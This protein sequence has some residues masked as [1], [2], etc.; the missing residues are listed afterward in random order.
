MFY[1]TFQDLIN[2]VQDD[3]SPRK[4]SHDVREILGEIDQKKTKTVDDVI[5]VIPHVK[6]LMAKPQR[7]L[8]DHSDYYVAVDLNTNTY[9]VCYR[10]LMMIDIDFY[11]E[12]EKITVDDPNNKTKSDKREKEL[13]GKIEDYALAKD[14]R[15]RIFRSRNGIHAFLI[16]READYQYALDLKLMLD[17]DCDFYYTVY[18][19]L[20]GWSVRLN[21][22][23]KEQQISYKYL[24]DVG[25][26]DSLDKLERLVDLHI[27]LID[28]FKDVDPST[29]FGI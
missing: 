11:K 15:F 20:R 5:R 26:V 25:D 16:S 21:R 13:I 7:L 14:L 19:H 12:Q 4:K 10:M 28:V 24:C 2:G 22:K 23:I 1:R 6:K 27:N 3:E 9:Y 8:H 29:M 17:L 18:S